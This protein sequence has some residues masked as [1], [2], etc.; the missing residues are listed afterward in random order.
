VKKQE[1]DQIV[2]AA[3]DNDVPVQYMVA[4]EE[5][6]GFQKE[7]N[8]LAVAAKLE[9]FFAQ[10]LGGRHQTN[11]APSVQKRLDA[12]AVAPESVTLPDTA[13][14][15]QAASDAP[16]GFELMD[17]STLQ[18]G[19]FSYDASMSM[20][21][22]SIDL[23]ATRTIASTST[24]GTDTWTIVNKTNTPRA[25]VTDSLIVD[26]GTLRPLSRHQRGPLT[27]DVTYTD[28]SASGSIQMRG[29]STSI[30][31]SFDRPTLAGGAHDLV[32]LS[33]M[34]LEPGFNTSLQVYSPQQQSVMTANFEVTGTT[35]VETPAGSFETY[36]VDV[37]VGDDRVTG[38]THLRKTAPH[39]V[40]KTNLTV[41]T[42]RG[43]RT[44]KQTLSKMSTPSSSTDTR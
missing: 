9:R 2:V 21:G 15:Q 17:G 27:M 14:T 6:H 25:T 5:G 13:A 10:H 23:S 36:V 44:I 12:L 16:S 20:Q 22:R 31:T 26:R 40:V 37:T 19:T 32:A 34:P 33:T 43:S 24:N 35:N 18:A 29:Q 42:A 30:G 3:R 4:P 7:H 28:T 38:T 1:S 41:S 8:R 11:A 39:H